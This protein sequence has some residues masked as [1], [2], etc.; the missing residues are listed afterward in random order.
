MTLVAASMFASSTFAWFSLNT[1]VQATGM[2][3]TA[4]SD[5][6][7]LLIGTG[8]SDTATEIQTGK[9]TEVNLSANAQV[10]P[11]AHTEAVTNT[12]TANSV[13][14]WY[15]KYADGPDAST[16]SKEEKVLTSENFAQ[17][18]IHQTVYVTLAVGSN[19]ASDLK[20]KEVAFTTNNASTVEGHTFAPVRVL[21][22]SSSASVELK[23]DTTFSETVLASSV[24]SSEAIQIDIF[25]YYDGNDGNVYTNN[26]SKL[27]GANI[28]ITFSVA[29]SGS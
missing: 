28:S 21:V 29:S 5:S 7:Y 26:K 9:L 20:V 2:Q 17:Y 13:A 6:V 27:D 10:Y 15:T 14:N 25:I 8:E 16:S 4:N 22:T 19:N 3:I 18:V 11:A 24:T 12:S 1:Q 23:N